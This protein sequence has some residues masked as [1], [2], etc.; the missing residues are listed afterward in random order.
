MAVGTAPYHRRT[1]SAVYRGQAL[2][3]ASRFLMVSWH[4]AM[5][6][7]TGGGLPTSS[8]QSASRVGLALPLHKRQLG[9]GLPAVRVGTFCMRESHSPRV[10]N[11]CEGSSGS[12][13]AQ[14]P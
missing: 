6:P 8:G 7:R 13:Y 11:L 4:R 5:A 1:D 9:T 12:K 2:T 3:E 10:T 14:L